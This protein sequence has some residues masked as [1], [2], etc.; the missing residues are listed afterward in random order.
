MRIFFYNEERK[1]SM[2]KPSKILSEV[3]LVGSSEISNSGD[4]MVYLVDCESELALVDAGVSAD[5]SKICK[6]IKRVGLDPKNISTLF[7]THSHMDH[8]G[9]AA[10]FR[11]TYGCKT[12]AHELDSDALE[13][14][15]AELTGAGWYNQ[16]LVPCKVDVKLVGSEGDVSVGNKTFRWFHTPGHTPGSISILLN[17]SDGNILFAQDVH[18]PFM[19]QFGSNISDWAKSMKKLID[20]DF[21]VLAEGHFGIYRPKDRAVE[22]IK[23]YLTHYGY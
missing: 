18:G 17:T 22:Y 4:C 12:V 15:D 19:P 13:R 7:I 9:G 21:D 16:K 20:L 8:V 5:I 23:S 1:A 3:Y 14:A 10:S 2:Q 6:N 11:E